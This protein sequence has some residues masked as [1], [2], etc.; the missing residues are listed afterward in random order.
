MCVFASNLVSTS[1]FIRPLRS[2]STTDHS[3]AMKARVSRSCSAISPHT[4]GR[5]GEKPLERKAAHAQNFMCTHKEW[6][7]RTCDASRLRPTDEASTAKMRQNINPDTVGKARGGTG[8][9]FHVQH[10]TCNAPM[11]FGVRLFRPVYISFLQGPF[12]SPLLLEPLRLFLT[13]SPRV[14]VSPLPPWLPL[15]SASLGSGRPSYHRAR[16]VR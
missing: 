7:K 8:N 9:V 12:C 13:S 2:R 5:E 11:L 4:C 6:R 14:A 10:S 1:A 3:H 16:Y 15:S